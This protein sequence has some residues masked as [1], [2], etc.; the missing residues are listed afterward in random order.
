MFDEQITTIAIGKVNDLFNYRG[1][2]VKIKTKSNLEGIKKIIESS[3][4]SK[5]S[6]IFANLV[7]FDVYY[8]HR[9]DPQGFYKALKEFDSHLPE[10]ISA[11]DQTD[12]LIITADHGN[13][14]TT[15]STDHSREY[16]PLLFYRKNK[17]G[18]N[19]GVRKTFSDAAQTVAEF[20]K[21]NNSLQG[22]TFL[23]E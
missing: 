17:A 3:E 16:V 12:A 10:I 8:G 4:N 13:D 11:I 22:T 23:N 2:K 7:D 9:D 15:P 14:P 18:K 21:I 5:D 19:L 20:F 6:L 1:I